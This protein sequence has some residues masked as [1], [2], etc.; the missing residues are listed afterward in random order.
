MDFLN[1]HRHEL[2]IQQAGTNGTQVTKAGAGVT[3]LKISLP[4]ELAAEANRRFQDYGDKY[5]V[6][7]LIDARIGGRP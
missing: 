2:H 1:Q 4:D 7:V 6:P 3:V 5:L